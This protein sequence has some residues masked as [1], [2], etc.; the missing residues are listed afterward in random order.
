MCTSRETALMGYL[1]PG[2]VNLLT[3][4]EILLLGGAGWSWHLNPAAG[5]VPRWEAANTVKG[6]EYG[7][8]GS[9]GQ[10]RNEGLKT[11]SVKRCE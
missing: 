10:Q 3:C 2:A 6:R 11:V 9:R 4:P 1:G 8:S 5:L 7:Y